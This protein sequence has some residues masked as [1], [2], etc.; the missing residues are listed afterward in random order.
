MHDGD[1]LL[2]RRVGTTIEG[3]VRHNGTW[4]LEISAQDSSLLGG[5]VGLGI[6]DWI[7]RW[8]N[9]GAGPYPGPGPDPDPRP[10]PGSRS[11]SRTRWASRSS[12]SATRTPPATGGHQLRPDRVHAFTHQLG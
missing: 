9:F 1:T 12:C 6:V 10:R 3:W 7:G 11:G 4:T 5:M 2:A 8:D